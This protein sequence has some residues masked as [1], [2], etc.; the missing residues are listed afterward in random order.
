MA[1]S[2]HESD[3]CAF[4]S[5]KLTVEVLNARCVVREVSIVM[6]PRRFRPLALTFGIQIDNGRSSEEDSHLVVMRCRSI[7]LR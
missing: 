5:E 6:K 3:S 2:A 1:R 4:I 7:T